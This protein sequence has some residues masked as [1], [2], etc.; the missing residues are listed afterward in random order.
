MPALLFQFAPL[1]TRR[2]E[3]TWA[4]SRQEK[5][6]LPVLSAH[7]IQAPTSAVRRWGSEV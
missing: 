2:E 7:T 4:N 1:L 3:A 5:A 6:G